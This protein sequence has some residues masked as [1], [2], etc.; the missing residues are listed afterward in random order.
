[1]KRISLFVFGI[2]CILV[3]VAGL[4]LPILPG[5]VFIF[6]GLSFIAPEFA[7]K[8]KRRILRKLSKKEIVYFDNWKK[9]GVRA[10]FTTRHFPVFLKNTDDLLNEDVQRRFHQALPLRTSYV[11]LN[12]VHGANIAVLEDEARFGEGFH[13]LIDTDGVV[14]RIKDL[15]LLVMTAD[16]LSIFFH[17]PATKASA[18]AC[19]TGR[20]RPKWVG[21]VHAGWRGTREGIAAKAFRLILD[22]AQCA[23]R[24]VHILFG[25]SIRKNYYEVGAEFQKYFPAVNKK[26]GKWYFDLAGENKRQLLRASAKPKNIWDTGL[27]TFSENEDFYS[28]RKEKEAAGRM[29]SFIFLK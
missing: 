4:I 27:C 1:M 6:L 21:L 9:F 12:Q 25:P 18:P 15:A 3:G 28:F 11:V 13:H 17:A 26:N 23:P 19:R 14:T 20:G 7:E 10:G 2:V 5:W 22:K 24:D 16:C 8:L 29:V